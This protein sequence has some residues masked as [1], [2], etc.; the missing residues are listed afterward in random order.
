MKNFFIIGFISL[1]IASSAFSQEAKQIQYLFQG[2]E[3]I[4]VSGF[5]GP[6][7][8]FSSINNEFALF[9]GGGGAVLFNHSF[10]IGGYG[11]GLTTGHYRYDLKDLSGISAPKIAFGHGGFW[12]GYIHQPL[13]AVHAGIS[14]KIGWG[15]VSLYNPYF[16]YAPH[17]YWARDGVFVF[18]PQLELEL[19]LFPWFKVNIGAGY[20]LVS[21]LN[22]T[23][24][25]PKR[26][27]YIQY[28]Q[29][30]DF[31]SFEG[32]VSFLFGWF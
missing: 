29:N 7:V 31:S 13:N 21:G 17:D 1:F 3:K 4:T 2:N 24:K 5:G 9:V 26:G 10:F 32:S 22:K 30:S 18:I 6:I 8:E 23:Y 15:Q 11:E 27:D 12:L 25:D 16:T 28:Y 14:S 20:R 19:N